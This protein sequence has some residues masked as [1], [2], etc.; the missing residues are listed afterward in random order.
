MSGDQEM[1]DLFVQESG[2]HIQALEA[3]L[4]LLEGNPS[5]SDLLNSVFRS[6]HSIKGA[7]G[8]FGFEPIVNLAHVMESV[9]SLLR[10]GEIHADGDMMTLLI[11]TS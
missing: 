5:D 9:M 8:F 11:S 6:V 7:A 4:I 3:N 10:D 1:M 2:E